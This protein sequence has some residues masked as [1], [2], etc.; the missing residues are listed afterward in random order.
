MS[1]Q[2]RILVVATRHSRSGC[3]DVAGQ[4][5]LLAVKAYRDQAVAVASQLPVFL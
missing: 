3:S 2:L 1:A 4:A 5:G